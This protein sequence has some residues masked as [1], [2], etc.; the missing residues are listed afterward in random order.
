MDR[1][2]AT[3]T[4]AGFF[5][6]AAAATAH[7]Q[8]QL[9]CPVLWDQ[10][11]KLRDDPNGV[12]FGIKVRD[13]ASDHFDALL[14]KQDECLSQE[15][16]PESVKKA[17]REFGLSVANRRNDYLMARD[18]AVR[19]NDMTS[20]AA[21]AADNAQKHGV[22]IPLSQRTGRPLEIWLQYLQGASSPALKWE[23]PD[24]G[25][26][27]MGWLDGDSIKKLAYYTNACW[28]S[29]MI[30]REAATVVKE[31]LDALV[32]FY[33]AIP[34]FAQRVEAV[35]PEDGNA[36]QLAELDAAYKQLLAPVQRLSLT[37]NYH[38]Q[39][40]SARQRLEN[41]H[42]RAGDQLCD[43]RYAQAQLPQAWRSAYYQVEAYQP[44][45]FL[46]LACATIG[47]GAQIKHLP[48][49]LFAK[50]GFEI[51]GRTRTVQVFVEAQRL[52]GRNPKA[53]VLMPVSA[54]IDGKAVTITSNN[55][56]AFN[57]ELFSASRNQ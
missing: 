13:W 26:K 38:P 37:V 5:L 25:S 41:L 32:K 18:K 4:A 8:L 36:A 57:A 34:A 28:Q 2:F 47:D 52:A 55:V 1:H 44:M 11:P 49:G 43:T 7:A 23:C 33:A 35:R 56:R 31:D 24:S 10:I 42:A 50:E 51:K 53:M 30:S 54:R 46:S 21:L 17:Q 12:L 14:A 9:S 48:S 39:L 6:A 19:A 45:T 27:K 3:R 20:N 29:G 22:D 16:S 15:R 40:N